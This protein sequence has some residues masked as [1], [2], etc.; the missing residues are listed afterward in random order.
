MGACWLRGLS[1]LTKPRIRSISKICECWSDSEIKQICC[2]CFAR[3][4]HTHP[5]QQPSKRTEN[6]LFRLEAVVDRPKRLSHPHDHRLDITHN[7]PMYVEAP[8][9]SLTIG[10]LTITGYENHGRNIG[11]SSLWTCPTANGRPRP[12]TS[13]HDGWPPTSE[14]ATSP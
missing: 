9:K 14:T 6:R 3:L 8:S 7:M 5:S 10:D 12:T 1:P 2:F 4:D 13:L 11:S